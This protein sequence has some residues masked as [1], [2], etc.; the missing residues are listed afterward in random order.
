MA[1]KKEHDAA[2]AK[3]AKEKKILLALAPLLAIAAFFAYHTMSKLHGSSG[4]TVAPAAATTPA[5]T[6]AVATTPTSTT[7]STATP[8]ATGTPVSATIAAPVDGRLTRLSLFS[9]KDPFHDQGPHVASS[10]T[11][12]GSGS[13]S[14]SAPSKK[15]KQSK[16]GKQAKSQPAK[17]SAAPVPAPTSAVVGINGKLYSVA[18]GQTIPLDAAFGSFVRLT[19]LTRR[20]A[21]LGGRDLGKPVRLSVGSSVKLTDQAGHTYVIV[22]FPPGTAVPGAPVTTTQTTTTTGP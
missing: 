9:A 19:G 12:S 2:R 18:V 16:Q 17:A 15:S 7:P 21:T 3:A 13:A 8:T 5:S 1:G 6:V 14:S 4:P 22:L 11:G 20:T 10:G